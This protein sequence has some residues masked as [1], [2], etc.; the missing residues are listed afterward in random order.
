MLQT[1]RAYEEPEETDGY[2]ILVDRLWPRGIKKEALRLDSW[3]KDIAPSPDLRRQFNH[4]SGKFE[5]FKE[6]YMKELE[7]NEAAPQFMENVVREAK[8]HPVTLVY[9]AKDTTHNHAVVLKEFI[10]NKIEKGEK[11]G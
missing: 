9:G 7:Q 3:E 6:E 4:D 2:R 1:K 10:E 5:W 11:D 8:M